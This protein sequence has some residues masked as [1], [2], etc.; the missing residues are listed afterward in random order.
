MDLSGRDSAAYT[1][2]G[3]SAT[4]RRLSGADAPTTYDLSR[5]AASGSTSSRGNTLEDATIYLGSSSG[6]TNSRV[7]T[8]PRAYSSRADSTRLPAAARR[9]ALSDRLRA[10]TADRADRSNGRTLAGDLAGRYTP[11]SNANSTALR[12]SRDS[13]LGLRDALGRQRTVARPGETRREAV[14]Q[15]SSRGASSAQRF[16]P[17]KAERVTAARTE[18]RIQQARADRKAVRTM[19]ARY[20]A[21]REQDNSLRQRMASASQ[22]AAVASDVALRMALASTPLPGLRGYGGV[23]L[24]GGNQSGYYGH[25]DRWGGYGHYGWSNWYWNSCFPA[26]NSWW[27]GS[28]GGWAFG[29][30]WGY[31][32]GNSWCYSPIWAW[33]CYYPSS[34]R[35][36]WPTYA[37]CSPTVVYNYYYDDSPVYREVIAQPADEVV[38]VAAEPAEMVVQNVSV[39]A[40]TEYMALG[41]RAFT[42][43]RYGDAVHYYAKAIEFAP[44]DGVLYLVLFDSLFATGD[45]HYAAFAL[46]RSLELN[47]EIATLG[48]D[49]RAFYG[50]PADFDQQLALLER[51]VSDH[52]ID[53]DARLVLAANYL[54]SLQPERCVELL[55]GGYSSDVQ[56]SSSGQ[57]LLAA[58]LE[59][60]TEKE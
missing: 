14:E 28:C 34:Y 51:Y 9:S 44:E 38:V 20:K 15:M 4:S 23:S 29:F 46:R 54:F 8:V 1:G 59:L 43:G 55:D 45:Y 19:N 58:G 31:G 49:K 27:W 24:R 17:A 42:E 10:A 33:P 35:Y 5:R 25:D 30:G 22:S 41:D 32:W 26:W 52:A 13:S 7:S 48:L 47:P 56:Q 18:Y 36:Y 60:L 16:D 40:A 2:S 53:D 57:V 3:S 6:R 39:R 12:T 11:S 21:A 37:Y 50:N